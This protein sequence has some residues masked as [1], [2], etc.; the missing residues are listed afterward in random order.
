MKYSIVTT[1]KGRLHYLLRSLPSF[2]AQSDAEVI[3]VDYDCPQDT[4]QVVRDQF[5]SV[6]VVKLEDRPIFNLAAARNAA[7][8]EATGTWLVFVD[9]DIVLADDFTA[10]LGALPRG[11]YGE[12]VG[13]NDVRGTCVVPADALRALEGYDDVIS[14][15]GCEDLDLYGRLRF[16][17]LQRHVFPLELLREVI[18]NTAEERIVFHD[19]GRKLGYARGK[20]Y[21][22]LKLLLCKIGGRL[23]LDRVLRQ[24]LWG[25]IDAIVRSP[26]VFEHEHYLDVPLPASEPDGMLPNCT[27][28]SSVRLSIKLAR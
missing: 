6:K 18:P 8:P 27:F 1:C 23:V 19:V 15:Y 12:W 20:A 17:G 7:L 16:A 13:A 5:P 24:E 2:V 22:E 4:A 28:A 10:K 25:A 26:D 11:F 9:S 14:G 21:R 3:V